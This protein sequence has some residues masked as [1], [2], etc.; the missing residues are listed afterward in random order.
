MTRLGAHDNSATHF[1]LNLQTGEEVRAR[2]V[3]IATGARYRRLDIANV[4]I[5]DPD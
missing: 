5:F 3:V 4:D 1:S 2:A